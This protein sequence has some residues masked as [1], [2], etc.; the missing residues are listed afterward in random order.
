MHDAAGADEVDFAGGVDEARRKDVEVIGDVSD[1]NSVACVVAACSPA[2]EVGTRGEDVDELSFA[3]VA[4]LG[5]EHE[6]HRHGVGSRGGC[7]GS[8]EGVSEVGFITS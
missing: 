6:C 2:A 5:A 7:W 3:F 8:C 1:D 4:P